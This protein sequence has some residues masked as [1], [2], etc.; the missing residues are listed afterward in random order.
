MSNPVILRFRQRRAARL[1][2]RLERRGQRPL[3]RQK[4][5]AFL[6]TAALE[7]YQF[8]ITHQPIR[9]P[10]L[11]AEF[12]GFRIV[13]LSD[14][15]HSSFLDEANIAEAVRR[16]N[17]LEPDLIALTGDYI[18]HA[19]DYIAGCARVL[20]QLRASHGV[21][22]VLGNHDHWTDGAM[23]AEA[24]EAEG[25]RVLCNEHTRIHR[26][27]ANLCVAGI[28]DVMVKRDD[29][30]AALAGTTCEEAR[31]LLAHNPAIIRE[32]AR[33]GVDL[34]LSGHTHGGQI[35]WQ[36]LTGKKDTPLRRWLQRPSRRFLRGHAVLGST[37]LYVNRGLGTVVVPLRYGCPPEITLLELQKR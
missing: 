8:E 2:R 23:M 1:E 31:V 12:H 13:Q 37:Q 22:A 33:A 7:P 17:A 25:I 30:P 3:I 36:L 14:V 27:R 32:A 21:F 29:L 16:A 35:N 18:S 26:G 9:I 34:V 24:L 20:G 10:R 5:A 6:H 28:D 11:P 4:L 15:H 19:T